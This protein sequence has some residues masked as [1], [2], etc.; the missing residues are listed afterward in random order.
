MTYDNMSVVD[1]MKSIELKGRYNFLYT[2]LY[3]ALKGGYISMLYPE[4]PKH[5]NQ[6][7]SLTEKGKL[8]RQ[9]YF[10]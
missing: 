5:R 1:L 7:Y 8:T 4:Q 2:Y 10:V 3:P 6:K 9:R